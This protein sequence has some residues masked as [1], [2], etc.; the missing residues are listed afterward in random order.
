MRRLKMYLTNYNIRL[1][2]SKPTLTEQEFDT[3][4]RMRKYR[5]TL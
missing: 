4:E 3:L 1:L 5:K 2:E